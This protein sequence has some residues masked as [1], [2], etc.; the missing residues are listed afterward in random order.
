MFNSLRYR[1]GTHYLKRSHGYF[2]AGDYRKGFKNLKRAI[3]IVPADEKLFNF[4]KQLRQL[5]EAHTGK[6]G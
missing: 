5:A 1:I 6:R 2:D 3:Q 4:G